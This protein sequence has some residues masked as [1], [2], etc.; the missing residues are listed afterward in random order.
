MTQ[1][2]FRKL[3]NSFCCWEIS[4][5]YL[6]IC[7]VDDHKRQEA[8]EEAA[9]NGHHHPRESQVFTSLVLLR[10]AYLHLQFDWIARRNAAA[11]GWST[12]RGRA[13]IQIEI[14]IKRGLERAVDRLKWRRWSEGEPVSE[15]VAAR[16]P[17]LDDEGTRVRDDDGQTG[18][19]E[20]E[21]EEELL[22]RLAILG[23][24]RTRKSGFFQAQIVPDSQQRRRHHQETEQPCTDDH[25]N[26][27]AFALDLVVPGRRGDQYVPAYGTALTS[28]P[29]KSA[30]KKGKTLRTCWWWWGPCWWEKRPRYRRRRK[31]T[32]CRWFRPA[33]TT[34]RRSVSPSEA[35]WRC[36]RADRT[37]PGSAQTPSLRENAA[38][39]C[40]TAPQPLMNCLSDDKFN[41]PLTD[42]LVQTKF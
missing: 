23:Q 20:S 28:T 9:E 33:P 26:D 4:L 32:D 36:R 25:C 22:G 12:Q 14:R 38:C 7:Y 6:I 11:A 10:F 31:G 18:N 24:D 34:G 19:E 2:L 42:V 1:P 37:Q 35:G 16:L 8:D 29:L 5:N 15:D 3:I 13:G 41:Q 40:V 39:G 30:V 21:S 17:D 27:V